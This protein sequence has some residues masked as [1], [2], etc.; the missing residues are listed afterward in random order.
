MSQAAL[1]LRKI[2]YHSAPATFNG[3]ER[4]EVHFTLLDFCQNST[5]RLECSC[6]KILLCAVYVSMAGAPPPISSPDPELGI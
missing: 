6:R 5:Q 2:H 4:V 1:F 3:Y